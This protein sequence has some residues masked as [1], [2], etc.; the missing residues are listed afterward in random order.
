MD[1]K[2]KT[3]AKDFFL[4]LGAL[5]LLVASATSLIALFFEI[6]NKQFPDSLQYWSDPYSGGIRLAIAA[7]FVLF[8]IY[9]VFLR[10]IRK[11]AE[12]NPEKRDLGIRKWLTYL[13][14]F[15][16]GATIVI[17]L[18]SIIN[19]FLGGEITT[20]FSLKALTV[21]VVA[22]GI[23]FYYISDLRRQLSQKFATTYAVITSIIVLI[24]LVVGFAVMGSPSLI[25]KMKLDNTRV[26]D[27]SSITREVSFFWQNQA[28]LPTKLEDV[29]KTRNYY[30]LPTDPETGE[31][32]EYRTTGKTSF[33]VCAV[34]DRSNKEDSEADKRSSGYY[35]DYQNTKWD[36][37]AG[38]NC[39]P[40]I[41]DPEF[42]PPLN[43]A[44]LKQVFELQG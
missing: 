5:V 43:N 36:H 15:A 35:D 6:I 20:R 24:S 37:T 39:F 2:P 19:L 9:L 18:I 29:T 32:Y 1:T 25:R 26:S 23:F 21:F 3:H 28:K 40:Q 30:S 11:D 8:P 42:Y 16:A 13:T 41:I 17:D 10:V 4:Y 27:L 12:A 7:L 31:A 44:G 22:G 33:E 38:R 34:F 14:L